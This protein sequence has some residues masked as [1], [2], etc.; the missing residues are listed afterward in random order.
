MALLLPSSAD[1]DLWVAECRQHGYRIGYTCGAFDI[2]HAGHA[3]YLQRARALCDR[4]LVAVNSDDSIERYKNPLGPVVP[5]AERAAVLQALACVDAVTF[6]DEPRPASQL[7]RWR[8]DFYI[9]GGDYGQG[10]LKSADLVRSY[11]GQVL[12]IP[13]RFHISTTAITQKILAR[14]LHEKPVLVSTNQRIVFLDRD[15]TL[16]EDVPYLSDPALVRL[17][18]GVGPGLAELQRLGFLLVIIT[19]QQGIGLGFVSMREFIAV[20]QALFEALAPYGVA[21]ARVL[22]C[23]HSLAL[24]C[25]CRKPGSLLIRKALEQFQARPEACY[26][27]GDRISDVEAAE[28]AG[29]V[30]IL[31]GSNGQRQGSFQA[32][33]FK[34]A[35][36]WIRSRELSCNVDATSASQ[37]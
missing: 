6:L 11:G 2:F 22:F 21:I 13:V 16:I 3:D 35:V 15:G 37:G 12:L 34:D 29:C 24:K 26:F 27:I 19:N 7:R 18:P 4:L 36:Q 30:S 8:P 25:E 32:V 10:E 17:L 20:N 9:K 23:P 31:V 1:V 14:N 5:Q 28:K 33:D